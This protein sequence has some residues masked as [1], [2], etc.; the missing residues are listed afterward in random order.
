MVRVRR[1][2]EILTDFGRM[3]PDT[4]DICRL[5]QLACVRAARHRHHSFQ[6]L[7]L[8]PRER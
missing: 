4:S 2:Q 5:L 7:A 1:Y 3:A 6:D 8:P